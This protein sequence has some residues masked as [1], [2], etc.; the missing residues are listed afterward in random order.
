MSPDG[1]LEDV[2][3][4][5]LWCI[6]GAAPDLPGVCLYEPTV[7]P[8]LTFTLEKLINTDNPA[9]EQGTVKKGKPW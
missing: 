1:V 3:L 2:I 9:T 7:V 5:Q 8:D 6:R 4:A